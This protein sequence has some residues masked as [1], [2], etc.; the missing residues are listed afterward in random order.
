MTD[1][2]ET[3]GD[4]VPT[5]VEPAWLDA[6]LDDPDLRVLDCTVHLDF[7]DETGERHSE[8]GQAD[9][10]ESHVPGSAYAPILTDLSADDPA[11]PYELPSPERFERAMEDLGVGDDSRV[12][13]Y[14]DEGNAWATRVWWMLRVFG[15]DRAGV[16]D[17]GWARWVDEDRPVSSE[18]ASPEPA[19]FTADFRPELVADRDDVLAS[20]DDDGTCIVNALRPEDHVGDGVNKYGRLGR[21]PSSVNVPAV[22]EEAI[23][24]E[25][26]CTYQS[27][28]TLRARFE[29]A[30]ATDAENVV[31]YCGGGIA[32]TSAAFALYLLGVDDVA[33]YDGSL[34]EW[35]AD[36]DLPMTTGEPAE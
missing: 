32:A 17:G 26:A 31:T 25:D 19:S 35:G 36:P 24:D 20:I 15:F 7:D 22:G 3:T 29:T 21:I 18:P 10:E 27:R 8:S 16:L 9:W 30:G 11:F 5:L 4:D 12:V 14:D 23:V 28:E 13:L 34:S 1:D 6:H 33:V 2:G